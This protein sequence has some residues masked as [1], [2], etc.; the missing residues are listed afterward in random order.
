MLGIK[1][2]QVKQ[3]LSQLAPSTA[4]AVPLAYVYKLQQTGEVAQGTTLDDY[5]LILR[6]STTTGDVQ[7]A[8]NRP[9]TGTLQEQRISCM[10]EG[11]DEGNSESRRINKQTELDCNDPEIPSLACTTSTSAATH[12]E[13]SLQNTPTFEY[14]R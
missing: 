9:K 6:N 1:Q 10:L 3:I 2:S 7:N 13:K 12:A 4:G 8:E 14:S 11:S 5:E